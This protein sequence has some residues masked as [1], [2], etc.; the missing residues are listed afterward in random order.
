MRRMV[1]AV[2]LHGVLVAGAALTLLPL[3]W[4]L[5]ASFMPAGEA[6][7]VP[8]RLV[9]STATLE[10]YQALFARL[11]L[12]RSLLNSAGLA[13]AVTL[14]SL[15]LN[16]TAGYAFAKLRFAGRER[17][18]RL[19][20]GALVIPAQVAMLPLFLM[21]RELGVVNT[22]WGVIVPGMASVFGI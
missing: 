3:L 21:L 22:Y 20:L 4:M 18:F 13:A 8:P 12:T 9:P 17:L 10:H 7:A 6:S 11:H 2:A 14:V 1:Q 19:L 16:S 5:A 15:F